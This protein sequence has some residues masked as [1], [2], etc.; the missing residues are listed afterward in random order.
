MT[1]SVANVLIERGFIDQKQLAVNFVKE[2]FTNPRRGYGGAVVQVFSKL[3]KSK[4][5]DPL[6]PAKEQFHG[7]LNFIGSSFSI[8]KFLFCD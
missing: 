5:V 1:I 3:R 8:L 7:L 2:Y 4:F 6:Q